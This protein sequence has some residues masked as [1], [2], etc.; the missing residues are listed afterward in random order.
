MTV[1]LQPQRILV[2]QNNP[3]LQG[4]FDTTTVFH[5]PS[6]L[7]SSKTFCVTFA[8]FIYANHQP[9]KLFWP[10]ISKDFELENG[11]KMTANRRSFLPE[12]FFT[13][14]CKHQADI[15]KKNRNRGQGITRHIVSTMCLRHGRVPQ[16]SW[17]TPLSEKSRGRRPQCCG[18]P[19]RVVG[20]GRDGTS[21][22]TYESRSCP[23]PLGRPVSRK[24]GKKIN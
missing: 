3:A 4:S 20:L 23:F 11:V 18:Q 1:A 6:R 12:L 5:T 21:Y 17:F 13:C 14:F 8:Y 22:G 7:N 10:S 2:F 19:L 24:A 16:T 15:A 9:E